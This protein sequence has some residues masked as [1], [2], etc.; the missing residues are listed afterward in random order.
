MAQQVKGTCHQACYVMEGDNQLLQIVC[1]PLPVHV[2]DTKIKLNKCQRDRGMGVFLKRNQITQRNKCTR[3]TGNTKGLAQKPGEQGWNLSAS[4][5]KG[6][7]I[8]G[9]SK[10]DGLQEPML[11]INIQRE[12]DYDRELEITNPIFIDHVSAEVGED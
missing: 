7:L 9:N 4:L 12:I 5:F 3:Y 6:L 2:T 10:R 8:L 11:K 1:C